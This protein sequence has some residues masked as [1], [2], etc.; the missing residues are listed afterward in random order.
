MVAGTYRLV[1]GY[2]NTMGVQLDAG[3][4]G[5]PEGTEL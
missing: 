1:S 5:W 2:L 4:Q 3:T